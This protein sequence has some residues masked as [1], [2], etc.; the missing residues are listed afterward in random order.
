M[1]RVDGQHST[2]HYNNQYTVDKVLDEIDPV[3]DFA[4]NVYYIA[5]DNGNSTIYLGD[6]LVGGVGSSWS[7]KGGWGMVPISADFGTV[8][9]ELGHA[10]GLSHDFR[11]DDYVMSYGYVPDWLLANQRLS[12]CNAEFLTVHTYFDPNSPIEDGSWPTIQENTSSPIH[13]SAGTT[14]IPVR[15]KGR[16]PDGLHQAILFTRTQAPHFA[17]GLLEV[18][19]CRGLEGKRNPVVEFD[20]D[21]FAPSRP[22][23]DFNTFETQSLLI[24][25]VDDLGN[26]EWSD[27]LEIINPEFKKPIAT[28][29]F[30]SDPPKYLASIGFSPDGK[31]LALESSFEDDK[32]TL[33][34][35]STGKSIANLPPYGPAVEDWALSPDGRLLALEAPNGTIVLWDIPSRKQHVATAPAHQQDE[36][37]P[38]KVASS[39]AFS[40]NG[41][42]LATGGRN[43]YLVKLWDVVSGEHVATFPAL[44][45]GGSITSLA[46]SPD[47]K[48]LGCV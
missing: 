21:G 37:F 6:L 8:A 22:G 34:D 39:L 41:K 35:V 48:R 28:F 46:F 33:R 5:I 20:Y 9:H 24:Q 16:D 30:P 2:E 15:I 14:S 7:K 38:S 44:R 40:P 11:D 4:E 26:T 12:A 17:E 23:S 27:L 32:V 18:K 47:G 42:L 13:I 25:V 10:F 29:P 19:A 31:L 36:G 1:H 45:Y 3:F 43:D